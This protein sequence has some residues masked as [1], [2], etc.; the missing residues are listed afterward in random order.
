MLA[1]HWTA[2]WAQAAP[3]PLSSSN[4]GAV[5]KSITDFVMRVTTESGTDFV[6][7]DKRVATFDNDGTLW[8]EQPVLF[9]GRLRARPRE[10]YGTTASRMEDA[11]AVQGLAVWRHEGG[12]G[13]R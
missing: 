12:S 1:G 5:K 2:V 4:E 10:G 11:A 3:D 9:S 8:T 7:F 13:I 6:P